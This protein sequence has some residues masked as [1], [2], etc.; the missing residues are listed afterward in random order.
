MNQRMLTISVLLPSLLV[1]AL[2]PGFA[3]QKKSTQKSIPHTQATSVAG[4][5]NSIVAGQTVDATGAPSSFIP[6]R[7]RNLNDGLVVGQ[8]T[9][10]HLAEFSFVVP[11][12]AIYIVEA[13]D[14]KTGR[15][16]AVGPV[17]SVEACEAVGV[18]VQLPGKSQ[19]F[20]GFFGNTAAAI[21][22]AAAAAGITA[23]TSTGNPVTPEQ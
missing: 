22:S 18:I 19:T 23:V 4:A 11:G 8:S 7:F 15:V 3:G 13:F 1:G 2:V 16:L 21:L 5:T 9:S 20:A 12:G 10:S 6:V 17:V 14:S